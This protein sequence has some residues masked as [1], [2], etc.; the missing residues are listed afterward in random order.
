MLKLKSLLAVCHGR[1][2]LSSRG[3]YFACIT[4]HNKDA[5]FSFLYSLC[6]TYYTHVHMISLLTLCLC[7]VVFQMRWNVLVKSD[8][9]HYIS[10]FMLLCLV[11]LFYCTFVSFDCDWECEG[12]FG[13]LYIIIHT[14]DAGYASM[15]LFWL[16]QKDVNCLWTF[17]DLIIEAVSAL[18]IEMNWLQG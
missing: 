16:G 9:M 10:H 14:A 12:A 11:S 15:I 13:F 4:L 1:N 17:L 2:V 5:F 7:C 8:V 6:T 3:L 18:E